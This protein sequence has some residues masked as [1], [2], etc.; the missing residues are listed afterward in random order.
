MIN[1]IRQSFKTTYKHIV[2]ICYVVSSIAS[3]LVVISELCNPSKQRRSFLVEVTYYPKFLRTTAME[4]SSAEI[5][6]PESALK[7]KMPQVRCL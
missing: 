7:V 5:I 2:H 4:K 1:G 6:I 3:C